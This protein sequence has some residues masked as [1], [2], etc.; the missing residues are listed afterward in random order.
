[1]RK[2]FLILCLAF[3]GC[4]TEDPEPELVKVTRYQFTFI[5]ACGTQTDPEVF[6]VHESLYGIFLNLELPA[7]EDPIGLEDVNG[8]WREG[9]LFSRKIVVTEERK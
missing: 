1:M 5:E 4:S 7:C 6:F 8:V 3:I 9:I 2:L